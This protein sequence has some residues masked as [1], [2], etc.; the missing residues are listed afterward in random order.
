MQIEQFLGFAAVSLALALVPGP[1]W[2]YV[3][4]ATVSR[5]RRAGFIA[6]LGNAC[7]IAGHVVAVAAGLAAVLSISASIY[8]IVKWLGAL[9]LLYLGV[10]TMRQPTSIPQSQSDDSPESTLRVFGN[11]VLVNLLNPKVA[12]VMLALL[13]QFI[14][15]TLGYAPAQLLLI[16]LVHPLIASLVLVTIVLVASGT[17]TRLRG[18]PRLGRLLRYAAGLM[19]VGLGLRLAFSN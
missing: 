7:G 14:D 4:S 13:P 17:T 18:R 3:I 1:S 9:Y 12:L 2:I 15:T 8:L 10:R 16:G 6:V 11:G 19:L 5:N